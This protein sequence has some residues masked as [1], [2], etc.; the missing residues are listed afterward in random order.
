[1]CGS[2]AS[3]ML[4]PMQSSLDAAGWLQTTRTGE[5]RPA[6][7]M[8]QISNIISGWDLPLQRCGGL[9]LCCLWRQC[10][11][12]LWRGSRCAAGLAC[13]GIAGGLEMPLDGV[14]LAC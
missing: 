5:G 3:L 13:Q 7:Q 1:M 11:V 6:S 10:N 12:W 9:V 4:A 14:L 2:V 8:A